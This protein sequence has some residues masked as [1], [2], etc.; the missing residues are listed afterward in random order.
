[1]GKVVL[2][3]VIIFVWVG[4]TSLALGLIFPLTQD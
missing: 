2:Y 4:A 1:M 3:N